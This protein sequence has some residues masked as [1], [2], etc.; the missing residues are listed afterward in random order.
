MARALDRD[1]FRVALVA[2]SRPELEAVA[3]GLANEPVVVVADLGDP[4]GPDEAVGGAMTA[5]GGRVD[6]LVNNAGAALMLPGSF[7]L[8]ITAPSVRF[9]AQTLGL[10]ENERLVKYAVL[11]S[12]QVWS[13]GPSKPFVDQAFASCQPQPL[14]RLGS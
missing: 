8:Q 10:P 14:S 12:T 11:P 6:V 4:A 9:T 1:G 2:R 7:R 13:N 3:E 5:F